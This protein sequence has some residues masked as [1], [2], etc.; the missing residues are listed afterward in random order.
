[1]LF[2]FQGTTVFEC[3]YPQE[4]VAKDLEDHLTAFQESKRVN[5]GVPFTLK[6]IDQFI[7]QAATGSRIYI[8]HINYK[9]TKSPANGIFHNPSA[10]ASPLNLAYQNY[11]PYRNIFKKKFHRDPCRYSLGGTFSSTYIHFDIPEVSVINTLLNNG[12]RLWIIIDPADTENLIAI[13][14]RVAGG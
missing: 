11:A 3:D 7:T 9:Q 13:L 4:E 1:M 8:Q 2:A 10:I 14:H 6:R 5:V 12:Y